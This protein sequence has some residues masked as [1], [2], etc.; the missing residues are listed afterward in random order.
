MEHYRSAK[1]PSADSYKDKPLAKH[2]REQHQD[3]RGEP[4]LKLQ[5][6]ERASSTMN[7][8]II[9]ARQILQNK[10]DLNDRDEQ[11]ELRKFLV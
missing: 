11:N 4:K 7:R 2:Y 8:K 9:E 5:I 3:F 6:L 10:P 1:N